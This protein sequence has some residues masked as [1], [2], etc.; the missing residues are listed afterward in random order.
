VYR[1]RRVD[2]GADADADVAAG[3][4]CRRQFSALN[5]AMDDQSPC[6]AE[7]TAPRIQ[8]DWPQ[9]IQLAAG[10][11]QLCTCRNSA[12]WPHCDHSQPDRCAQAHTMTLAKA[13]FVWMCQCGNSAEHPFCDGEGHISTAHC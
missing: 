1:L 10:N 7:H 6:D 8:K 9:A 3:I 12:N 2:T 13:R 4:I 11:H 5:P